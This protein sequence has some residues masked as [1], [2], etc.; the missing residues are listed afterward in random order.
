MQLSAK[1]DS[2]GSKQSNTCLYIHKDKKI[3]YAS[4]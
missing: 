2:S 1:E 4:K 3:H